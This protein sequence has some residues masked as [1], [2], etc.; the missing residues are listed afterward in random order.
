MGKTRNVV[1]YA[2][3]RRIIVSGNQPDFHYAAVL[4][5]FLVSCS[6][7]LYLYGTLRQANGVL[8]ILPADELL[9]APACL[10]IRVLDGR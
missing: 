5:F 10:V 4:S 7:G 6:R 2:A 1:N 9:Y 3:G 8:L